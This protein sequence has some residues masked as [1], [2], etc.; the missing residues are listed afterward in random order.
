[1]KK[2]F[3]FI[4]IGLTLLAIPATI[5]F[6]GQQRDVRTHAAP[7]TTLALT[8][9]TQTANVGDTLKLNFSHIRSG[10]T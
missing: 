5:Y 3:L 4:G 2:V 9:A 7:A 1:M 10:E 6:L 8:P